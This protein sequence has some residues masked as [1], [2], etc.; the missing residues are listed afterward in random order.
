MEFYD[1][2]DTTPV[3]AT[4]KV[5]K[6]KELYVPSGT[7]QADDYTGEEWR[8]RQSVEWDGDELHSQSSKLD[9]SEFDY[10]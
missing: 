7:F 6:G 8:I 4:K 10:L 3:Q 2:W 9:F 5:V 1:K